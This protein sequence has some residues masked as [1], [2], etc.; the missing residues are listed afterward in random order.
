MKDGRIRKALAVLM[1][2]VL[3]LP[4][5]SEAE[6]EEWVVLQD[7][8]PADWPILNEAGYLDEGEFVYEDPENG[9]WRPE[10]PHFRWR[11]A[12]MPARGRLSL[13]RPLFR[14]R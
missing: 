9:I 10:K 13:L 7:E 14:R 5:M 6:T 12:C 11:S 3:L 1:V 4:G 8:N 2:A